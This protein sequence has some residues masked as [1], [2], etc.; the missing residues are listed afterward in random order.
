MPLKR[1]HG[2]GFTILE[3]MVSV[4]IVAVVSALAYSGI[5]ALR[6]STRR[7]SVSADL[8]SGIGLAR[9]RAMARQRTQLIVLKTVGPAT[10]PFGFYHFEDQYPTAPATTEILTAADVNAIVS[11]LD[12]TNLS[13]VP[14]GYGLTRVNESTTTFNGFQQTADAWNGKPLPFP[15]A[16]LATSVGGPVNTGGGCTFCTGGAGGIGL[17]PNG[18]VVFSDSNTVGGLVVIRQLTENP[19]APISRV[20]GVAVSPSG[21]VQLVE[22]Q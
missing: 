13:T 6:E 9:A 17:L 15:W 7:R 18:R 22:P 19:N 1:S 8:Y 11:V 20:T 2:K 4:S 14:S 10:G 16:A 12:P 3:M 21:F 5:G